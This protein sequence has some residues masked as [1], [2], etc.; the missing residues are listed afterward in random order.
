MREVFSEWYYPDDE[1]I[2][3]I[4]TEGTIALDANA[5]LDLYRVGAGRR[6]EILTA[7]EK[8]G[9]RLFVPYQAAYEYQKNR[10]SALHDAQNTF[11][12]VAE[13]LQKAAE[14]TLDTAL[15]PIRDQAVRNEIREAFTGSF[16]AFKSKYAELRANH[17][18]D[19]K[20]ARTNDPVRD[21][22][23]RIASG[24]RLGKK[25]SAQSL[26]ER[27]EEAQKRIDEGRP[28]GN[29]DAKNKADA[30]G[31]YLVWAELLEHAKNA[32]RPILFVT[33]DSKKGDWFSTVHG[34]IMGPL[35]ELVA[36]MAGASPGHSYHQVMLDSLLW[37]TN[38]YINTKVSEDTIRTLRELK[39]ITA[40]RSAKQLTARQAALVAKLIAEASSSNDNNLRKLEKRLIAHAMEGITI[41]SDEDEP[42][43]VEIAMRFAQEEA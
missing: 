10:T 5:L 35:P 34:R 42:R 27:R 8:I 7:L 1:V 6:Q 11:D 24:P 3:H 22:L 40:L 37:L 33:N 2:A 43:D 13:D 4:V 36:E 21:E 17:I 15:K 25:P 19:L 23:D 18:L 39:E 29:A 14:D 38:K 9:D 41:S 12:R 26:Q 28:P 20:E 31:D 32:N 16:E 30:T